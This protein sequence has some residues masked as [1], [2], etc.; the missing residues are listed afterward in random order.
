MFELSLNFRLEYAE[1][2]HNEH[3]KVF[4]NDCLAGRMKI[5]T[6]RLVFRCA[7]NPFTNYLP[8]LPKFFH[9][10]PLEKLMNDPLVVCALYP[11]ALRC[12]L[13]NY[14]RLGESELHRS[15]YPEDEPEEVDLSFLTLNDDDDA[16]DDFDY[17]DDAHKVYEK[18][19]SLRNAPA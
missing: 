4:I 5:K 6:D 12:Y 7:S 9:K 11:I 2:H 13:R 1:D 10:V 19:L 16:E 8:N 3:V 15:D 17:S 14:A 18:L